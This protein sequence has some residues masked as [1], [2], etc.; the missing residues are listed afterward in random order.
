MT[1]C[2][3]AALALLTTG[4]YPSQARSPQPIRARMRLQRTVPYDPEP[5]HQLLPSGRLQMTI[6][7]GSIALASVTVSFCPRRHAV[8]HHRRAQDY[9]H[10][11]GQ[12]QG[13]RAHVSAGPLA[14]GLLWVIVEGGH[15]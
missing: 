8:Q 13:Q 5:R 2:S 4:N 11:Q 9:S 14:D 10:G 3:I 12:G 1:T 15:L 7:L 6:E